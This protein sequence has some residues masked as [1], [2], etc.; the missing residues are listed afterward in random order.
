M[1]RILGARFLGVALLL[2]LVPFMPGDAKSLKQTCKDRCVT[3]Y[4]FC[5]T[6]SLTS[7]GRSECK[8]ERKMCKTGCGT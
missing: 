3:E 5:L 6:R 8:T 1:V 7:K 2:L 4:R